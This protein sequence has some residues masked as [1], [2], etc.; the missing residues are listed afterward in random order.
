[1]LKPFQ[2]FLLQ[3]FNKMNCLKEGRGMNVTKN[4]LCY[5]FYPKLKLK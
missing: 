3:A 1:M 4:K 2:I 5:L